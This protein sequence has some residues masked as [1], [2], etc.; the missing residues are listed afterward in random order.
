MTETVAVYECHNT[1]C[2]L[3]TPG[4]P[5]RFTGGATKEQITTITGN[6]EPDKFGDGVCPNC[7][8][9][10][11]KAGTEPAPHKGRDPNRRFHEEVEARVNDPEDKLNVNTAQDELT[12]LVEGATDA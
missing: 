12:R 6:P 2:T 8:Q 9:P 10:G 1:A 4:T 11:T 7:G 3:G 5:G